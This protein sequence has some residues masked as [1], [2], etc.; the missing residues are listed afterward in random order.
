MDQQELQKQIALYYSKLPAEVQ[1]VF[2]KME[3]LETLKKISEKYILNN[4]Q[5]QTLG[6]E[7]TLLLL[8]IISFEEYEDYIKNLGLTLEN[9][10]KMMTEINETV[11]KEIR[12]R[13]DETF[14]ENAKTLAKE[15]GEIKEDL[16]IRFDKLAPEIKKVIMDIGYHTTLYNIAVA[17]KLD[18]PKMG[19]LEEITTSVIVGDL[20]PDQYEYTLRDKLG[21]SLETTQKLADEINKKILKIIREKMEIYYGK[22][23]TKIDSRADT[24]GIKII[25]PDLSLPELEAGE[26]TSKESS[27]IKIKTILDQKLT[28][29]VKNQNIKTDY[30]LKNLPTSEQKSNTKTDPYR[31]IPE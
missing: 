29:E 1:V 8:G 26:T 15:Q 22:S 18:I 11:L 2:A 27:K 28:G 17:N 31:E 7:T 21:L 23:S 16:D 10:D 4:E 14:Y 19:I 6:T 3:W 25:K 5:I 12:P 30:T 24:S 9:T 20:H 13:L